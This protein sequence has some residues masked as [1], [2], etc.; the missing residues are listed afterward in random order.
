MSEAFEEVFGDGVAGL[1]GGLKER[2]VGIV[3]ENLGLE[4]SGG[5]MGDGGFVTKGEGEEDVHGGAALHVG[6]EF[7]GEVGGDFGGGDL[8]END[9]LEEV[10]LFTGGAGGAGE[11]VVD[12]ELQGVFAVLV[13]GLLNLGDDF[14]EQSCAINGFGVQS[15]FFAVCDLF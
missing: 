1:E 7:E 14:G 11:G 8:A 5:G 2:H 10:G 13:V 4:D 9:F 3:E 15:L 12:E 6:E